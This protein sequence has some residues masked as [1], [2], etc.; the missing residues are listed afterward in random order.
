MNS[1]K[2]SCKPISMRLLILRLKLRELMRNTCKKNKKQRA[3]SKSFKRSLN[4]NNIMKII[5]AKSIE[6]VVYKQGKVNLKIFLSVKIIQ[7][8]IFLISQT[9]LFLKIMIM[10]F[11]IKIYKRLMEKLIL[12]KINRLKYLKKMAAK[13]SLHHNFQNTSTKFQANPKI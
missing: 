12:N 5:N 3:Y 2:D 11:L 1:L 8:K 6:I 9:L 7:K 4:I 10:I 13:I